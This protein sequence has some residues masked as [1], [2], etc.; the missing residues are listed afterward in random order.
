MDATFSYSVNPGELRARYHEGIDLILRAWQADEPFAFN[1][2]FSQL[3]YVNPTPRPMQ[4]PAP[5]IWIPG[6]GSVETWDFCAENDFVYG[7][8]TY[9][10]HAAARENI[11]RYWERVEAA[12]R[13][14]N[15]YR[16]A[17][18]QFIGVADT[19]KEAYE[20]YREP[21]EY[22]FNRCIHVHP[23]FANPPGYMTEASI[24][25]R[26]SS[27]VWR[28][29]R[30]KRVKHELTWDEMLSEGYM[31]VGSPDTVRENLE[32]ACRSLNVGNLVTLLHFGNMS[33]DLTRHNSRLFADKVAPGLRSLHAGSGYEHEWW[34]ANAQ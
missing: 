20:L 4:K 32:D 8:L 29:A 14:D 25:S 33:D 24:R 18:T 17:L 10:G 27:Q 7:M 6:G 5:P 12:G 31:V 22:F 11:E 16:L 34:P 13:D 2:R 9:Y 19:D 26:Y 21:A 28:A 3:R 23:G 1:G 30:A 15:P